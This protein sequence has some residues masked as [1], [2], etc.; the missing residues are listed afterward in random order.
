MI[1][2]MTG[3]GK[4][5]VHFSHKKIT[6]QLRSL[7][8]KKLDIYA[9]IPSEYKEKEIE[10]NKQISSALGRGKIDFSLLVENTG[11]TTSSK[12]NRAVVQ[13]YME[14][15]RKMVPN[16]ELTEVEL[17]KMAVKFPQS[18]T[19][20]MEEIDEAE[21]EAIQGGL[22][23]ALIQLNQYRS[24]EGNALQADF[25]LRIKNLKQLLD[26]VIA[27]DPDRIKSTRERLENAVNELKVEVDQNRFEQELVYYLE[28]YDIT[29]EKTR[30]SNHLS[31]FS[32]TMAL[33]ESSGRKLGFI[34]QEMGREINTIGSKSN[35]APMQ[36]LVVRMKDE[37]EKIKEQILNVL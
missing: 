7:N 35:F 33:Q 3:F 10:L 13:N 4:S 15:L 8:S 5:V 22:T 28:K 21:F 20:E 2:S 26:E 12:L 23:E 18:L 36:K 19:T 16:T 24:D 6:V 25:E 17:L 30:L 27:I 37:L 32:E 29:E 1:Q 11:G 31:Y 9:R 34:A 14:E